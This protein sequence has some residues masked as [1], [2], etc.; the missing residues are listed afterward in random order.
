MYCFIAIRINNSEEFAKNYHNNYRVMSAFF[1]IFVKR[2]QGE[3]E[4][5]YVYCISLGRVTPN[6]PPCAED[7]RRLSIPR[8]HDRLKLISSS[9]SL[10]VEK[11][12]RSTRAPSEI[13]NPRFT[14]SRFVT[15]LR[16]SA[17]HTPWDRNYPN[18]GRGLFITPQIDSAALWFRRVYTRPVNHSPG[19]LSNKFYLL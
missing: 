14:Q 4:I 1:R 7:F 8:G 18:D 13:V 6:S 16:T 12:H 19:I 2:P 17:T 9:F 5:L 15:V 3:R 11:G 10:P